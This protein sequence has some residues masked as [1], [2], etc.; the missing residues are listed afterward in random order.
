MENSITKTIREIA[1]HLNCGE[2]CYYN[3]NTNKLITIPQFVE[4]YEDEEFME[5]FQDEIKKVKNN[6]ADYMK[7]SVLESF[8]SFKIMEKFIDEI[9]EQNFKNRL[10]EILE[11]K[12]PFRNFK[13]EVEN[14]AYREAWFEFKKKETEKIVENILK[15]V[16]NGNY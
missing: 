12:K 6:K 2:N 15:N 14:S 11:R 4:D 3:S 1:S 9:S 5:P 8:E 13:D 7:I 10:T 16:E